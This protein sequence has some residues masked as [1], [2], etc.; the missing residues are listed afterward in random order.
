MFLCNWKSL[1][2]HRNGHFCLRAA[3]LIFWITSRIFNH[4]SCF[5]SCLV[6]VDVDIV[7]LSPVL[8]VPSM[9]YR[10]RYRGLR[11]VD[12]RR[13]YNA[14][15]IPC[16]SRT[17]VFYA[18]TSIAGAVPAPEFGPPPPPPPPRLPFPP[19]FFPPSS[20]SCSPDAR[21]FIAAPRA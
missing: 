20:P 3:Y 15:A 2:L 14:H 12:C 18:A 11:R 9:Y 17:K 19:C 4:S 8:S 5:V 16:I 13:R 21:R 7:R 1:L 10:D 6:Y